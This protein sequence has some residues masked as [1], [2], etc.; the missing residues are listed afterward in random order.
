MKLSRRKFMALASA[1]AA[2]GCSD[3]DIAQDPDA[4]APIE[5]AGPDPVYDANPIDLDG[6]IDDAA[7]DDASDDVSD[8][9]APADVSLDAGR[10]AS[11]DAG[12]DARAD[13]VSDAP[14]DVIRDVS[15]DDG[16]RVDAAR[17]AG[18]VLENPDFRGLPERAA[19]FPIGV[20]AGDALDTSAMF[21]TRYEGDAAVTLRVLEMDGSRIT[22]V[23][24]NGRV[25]PSA[26][27]FV[28]AIVTGLRANKQHL[29]AFLLGPAERPTGRSAVG[30]VETAPG[31]DSMR[32]ITF[33]G[34]SCTNQAHR[35]FP[36]M[37][38]AGSRTDLDFFLHVGD[39]TYTD[40]GDNATTLA[41][42]RAKYVENWSSS[43][44]R[45]LHRS[46][47][48]YLTW[49]DHEV[50]NNWNPETLSASRLAMARQAFFEFR[51]TRRN[52]DHPERIWRSFRWGRTAEIFVL[53][54][55]S[56]RLPSTRSQ[57]PSRSSQYISR[58]QM[59]WLKAGL[60]NSP[61]VFKFI[62]NS[63]PIVDRG[64]AGSDNWNGY[65]SQ[66]REILNHIANN[67]LRGVVWLSGDVHF[68]GVCRVESSGA[69]SDIWEVVMGPG[70]NHRDTRP[71]IRPA[72]WPVF[73]Y[74]VHNYAVLRAN[75]TTR[76]LDVEFI[77]GAGS[78]IAGS[79][80]T[81]RF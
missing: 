21:W 67:D 10:D 35:P 61:C 38:H 23:R 58:A 59:D 2:A 16:A 27:G 81:R 32:A 24:F 14:R 70:G 75:P 4:E 15:S 8:G 50:V 79:H 33:G 6:S 39:H 5:D 76:V 69:W 56:E 51:A 13:A 20:M 74:D 77:N 64:G 3:G 19:Q 46:T 12:L 36:A 63:V 52:G 71:D 29:Y 47:G 11:L 57:D 43:G 49:D 31:A 62:A 53:D 42:Y 30:R 65:A 41:Q 55:R 44:L 80:W 78:R 18:I 34:T 1:A 22:A 68:G 26:A 66:R 45:A 28:R 48:M 37:Q 9:G 17:D 72:Q 7:S 54:C 25:T 60:R 73:V 40:H